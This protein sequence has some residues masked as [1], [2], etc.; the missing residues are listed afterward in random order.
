MTYTFVISGPCRTKKTS[1]QFGTVKGK[2][3]KFPAAA[4]RKWARDAR[5]GYGGGLLVYSKTVALF[6][7]TP[8][9]MPSGAKRWTPIDG[10]HNV[11]A[12]FYLE[13]RQR[14]DAL[15][16][17]QGLADLLQARGVIVNDRILVS[18]NGS[19]CIHD[20]TTPR[21]EVTLEPLGVPHA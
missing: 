2:R 17:F 5:I 1:D 3:M 19:R 8:M 10:A 11:R 13:P 12:L 6:V 15:G 16:Y 20:G 21:A 7:A 18:W 9:Q 14:G 4:W